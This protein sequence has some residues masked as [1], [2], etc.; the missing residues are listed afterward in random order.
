MGDISSRV[1][2]SDPAL[3]KC[4][5]K[6]LGFYQIESGP[7]R[8]VGVDVNLFVKELGMCVVGQGEGG[9]MGRVEVSLEALGVKVSEC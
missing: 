3:N 4:N 2:V 7:N 1:N 6:A 9:G 8:E 5:F